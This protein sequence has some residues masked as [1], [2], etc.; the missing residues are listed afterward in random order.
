MGQHDQG[1][2]PEIGCLC[3]DRRSCAVR[4][5]KILRGQHCLGGFLADRIGYRQTFL[6]TAALQALG[7][8]LYVPLLWLVAMEGAPSPTAKQRRA[9]AGASSERAAPLLEAREG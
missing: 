2:K 4:T 9:V 7:A 5:V 8:L 1:V 6:V 3:D